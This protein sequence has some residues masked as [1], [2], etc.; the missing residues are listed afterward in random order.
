MDDESLN[1]KAVCNVLRTLIRLMLPEDSWQT[2]LFTTFIVAIR[3]RSSGGDA[4]ICEV[5]SF[6]SEL[7]GSNCAKI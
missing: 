2:L 5:T 1:S 6:R 3:L 4:S 7:A